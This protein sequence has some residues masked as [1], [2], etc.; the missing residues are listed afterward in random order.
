VAPPPPL[1]SDVRW[2]KAI[3]QQLVFQEL[4]RLE[5]YIPDARGLTCVMRELKGTW[6][7][8]QE[9]GHLSTDQI[10]AL[11]PQFVDLIGSLDALTEKHEKMQKDR[12]TLEEL[13]QDLS[14][15]D[16]LSS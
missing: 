11:E 1:T 12:V 6:K 7:G 10:E 15:L 5:E 8:L 13:V 14:Y 4:L 9:A 2:Q 3:E 16:L